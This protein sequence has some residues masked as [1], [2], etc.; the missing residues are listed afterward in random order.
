MSESCAISG[1]SLTYFTCMILYKKREQLQSTEVTVIMNEQGLHL[2]SLSSGHTD[3][4][5]VACQ[6][7][8][9]NTHH[10]KRK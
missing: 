5:A 7:F 6:S 8:W 4:G 9:E 3:H 2:I 10:E 1:L